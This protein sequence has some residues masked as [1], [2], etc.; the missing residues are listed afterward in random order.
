MYSKALTEASHSFNAAAGG[1]GAGSGGADADQA[2]KADVI[3]CA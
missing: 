1:G 2:Y 3:V